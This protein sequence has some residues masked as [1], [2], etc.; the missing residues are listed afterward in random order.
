M[1]IL[2][3]IRRQIF[4][5]YNIHK[6]CIIIKAGAGF[7]VVI[8]FKLIS[9]GNEMRPAREPKKN[10]M[11]LSVTRDILTELDNMSMP[12]H[13]RVGL[14]RRQGGRESRFDTKYYY[15]T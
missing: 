2:K 10:L 11:P 12:C 8:G 7:V 14:S 9:L 1:L 4:S 13:S 5:L 6:Y 3:N 15:I